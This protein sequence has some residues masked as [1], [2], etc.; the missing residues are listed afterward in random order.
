[1]EISK[2]FR[3]G[4]RSPEYYNLTKQ[5]PTNSNIIY[6]IHDEGVHNDYDGS[7]QPHVLNNTFGAG[8]NFSHLGHDIKKGIHKTSNI[9][10]S[11][12][13]QVPVKIA[14]VAS[15]I[16]QIAGTVGAGLPKDNPDRI[17]NI[18]PAEQ[19]YHKEQKNTKDMVDKSHPI[20][21]KLKTHGWKHDAIVHYM[22]NKIL[23]QVYIPPSNLLNRIKS[24]HWSNHKSFVDD[25]IRG[26]GK[27]KQIKNMMK[28]SDYKTMLKQI[29]KPIHTQTKHKNML[30]KNISNDIQKFAGGQHSIN[31]SLMEGGQLNEVQGS[32]KSTLTSGK[33]TSNARKLAQHIYEY[34]PDL[35]RDSHIS[36]FYSLGP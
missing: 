29:P 4:K 16:A 36:T 34:N 26:G 19:T 35:K 14:G 20:Y 10:N 22:K 9:I 31:R 1:M 3:G 30:H 12:Y 6:Q 8:F 28:N 32:I 23:N 27:R 11:K 33:Q 25:T 7:I 21:V 18:S 15:T 17:V 24:T 13:V 5:L 2:A